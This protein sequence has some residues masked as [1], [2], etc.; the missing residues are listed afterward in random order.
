MLETYR[1]DSAK[2]KLTK[3]AKIQSNSWIN[4]TD[5]STEEIE[6]LTKKLHIP[7]D[8]IYYSLDADE[9]AR[10]EHDPDYNATLI[11]FNIPI[12]EKDPQKSDKY[13]YKTSPLGIIVTD[14]TV[15]TINK[16]PVTFLQSFV[17]GQIKGF[18][19]Q[20]HRRSVLQILF[21]ISSIYLQY[22]RDIN[23][24]RE[25][26]ETRLQSSLRNEELFDLMTIQRGLV[27]FMMSLKTDKMVLASLM[28]TN[29]LDLNED[30]I[31]LLDDIQ[32]EN[33]QAIEMAEISNTI[34]NETADTYSSIINNNM[35]SVMK[36]LASYSIILTIPG[37]VFSFYGMN[38]DLPLSHS[39][40]S[41]LITLFISLIISGVLVYRFWR[42]RY[43]K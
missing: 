40:T 5:P 30:E 19:P 41:W 1:F 34:I 20:N 8:F 11:I 15:L 43:I 23:R 3:H 4:V 6:L 10:A 39:K 33:Q 27:Y 12:L 9:S 32:I 31:E 24:S 37:L 25:Q 17:D 13:L 21:R 16:T 36:F 22:L 28:R 2:K 42:K 18:N 35:N 14:S 7:S 29:M 26:I 38:V